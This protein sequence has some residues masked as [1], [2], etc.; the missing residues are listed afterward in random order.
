MSDPFWLSEAWQELGQREIQGL[1]NNS[2]ITAFISELGHASVARDETPWCAAFVGAV[3]ERSGIESTRSLMARSY[4]EWGEDAENEALGSIAVLSRGANPIYGH[5]GFLVGSTDSRIW[6][7]GGNQT[8]SVNVTGFSRSRLLGLRWPSGEDERVDDLFERALAHVLKMEGGFTDD[9]H[10]PGGPTNKGV[11]LRNYASYRKTALNASSRARLLHDLKEISDST[12]RDIYFKRYWR[13][14]QCSSMPAPLAFMHFDAAVN[15]GVTGAARILQEAA[16][17]EVDGEIGPIT[18]RTIMNLPILE[19]IRT[20]ARIREGK[21]RS[22]GHFWRFGRGWLRR[23][24]ET[25]DGAE[26]LVEQRQADVEADAGSDA[27]LGKEESK[28]TKEKVADQ[29][30]KWWGQSMTIWGALIT[31]A[32]TVLPTFGPLVGLDV[33]SDQVH[34]VGEEVIDVGHAIVGLIGTFMTIYGRAR[35]DRPLSLD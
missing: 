18:K 28:M 14:A 21:Y 19:L 26:G 4:L 32:A 30:T 16:D 13:P 15:H 17:V 22:M 2:R 33:S 35:A 24:S 11:T 27:R 8:N 3:L 5:V 20:Y 7:L 34:Q 1:R 9:P 25:L 23:V 31:A 10:D 12:V 29:P 6:L